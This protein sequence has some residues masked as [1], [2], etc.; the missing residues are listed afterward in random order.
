MV[1][2]VYLDNKEKELENI[3]NK[4]KSMVIRGAA[5]RKI[6]HS[7]VE[8]GETLF[9][10]EKGSKEIHYKA[11]V[12]DVKNYTK[13]ADDEIKNVIDSNQVK[14]NLSNK[15][16]KRWHKKCI[17]LVE[18]KELTKIDTL[19]FEHQSNMDDWLILERIEDVLVGTSKPYDYSKSKLK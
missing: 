2:L 14:L 4:S 1:H 3:I 9:F 16:K 13:L 18:F 5:G 17:I 8:I 12:S 11:I 10:M 6:P 15:Q 19:H 7:R